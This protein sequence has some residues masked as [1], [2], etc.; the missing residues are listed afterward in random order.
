MCRDVR[1]GKRPALGWPASPAGLAVSSAAASWVAATAQ[2][3]GKRATI[4]FDGARL[5]RELANEWQRSRA[6]GKGSGK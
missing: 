6:Q 2:A 1:P 5:W 3:N 4:D